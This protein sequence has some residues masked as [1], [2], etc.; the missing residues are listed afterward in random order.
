M[1]SHHRDLLWQWQVDIYSFFQWLDV[2]PSEVLHSKE[3]PLGTLQWLN[4]T[5]VNKMNKEK[6]E[7]EKTTKNHFAL[8]EIWTNELCL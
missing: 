3:G 7:E 1:F 2:I 6:E 4:R 8:A 5:T